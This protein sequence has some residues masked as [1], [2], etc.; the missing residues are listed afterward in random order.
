MK[1]NKKS[2]SWL[3]SINIDVPE[4]TIFI[5]VNK[6]NNQII[7]FLKKNEIKSSS[8]NDVTDELEDIN[9][10]TSGFF[11]RT[12]DGLRFLWLKD[13]TGTWDDL[14]TL[15]HEL[16]HF[17]DFES[18]YRSFKGEHEFKAY[19]HESTFKR[20][21]ILFFKLIDKQNNMACKTKKK[22]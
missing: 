14:D 11:I 3:G 13:F 12:R 9:E 22:K 17:V 15:N 8:V 7:S 6:T 10:K 5:A 21:R 18:S 4:L 20:L 1:K 16:F 2:I 19:L